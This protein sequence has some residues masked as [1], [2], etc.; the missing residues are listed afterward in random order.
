MELNFSKSAEEQLVNY[1]ASQ[2]RHEMD[3]TILDIINFEFTGV[4]TKHMIESKR[5]SLKYAISELENYKEFRK[6]SSWPFDKVYSVAECD[7]MINNYVMEISN[8]RKFLAKYGTG[9]QV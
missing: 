5:E 7:R 8:C 6:V 4:P 2:I 9:G 3:L 1:A